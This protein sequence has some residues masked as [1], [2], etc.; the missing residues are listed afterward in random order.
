VIKKI[1][2][3][4]SKILQNDRGMALLLTIT[5]ITLFVAGAL[6]LNKRVRVAVMSTATSRDR[7]TLLHMASSGVHAAMAMLVKDRIDSDTDSL[8]EDWADQ[9]ILNDLVMDI[10]FE[11]G[12]VKITIT[13]EL[14]KI[15]VNALVDFPEGTN[16]KEPQRKMWDRFLFLFFSQY[17]PDMRSDPDEIINSLKDWLDS[18]D[19]DVIT[20]LSGAESDYYQD[21][22]PPY[23]CRNGP[24]SYLGELVL[25][26]GITPEIFNDLGQASGLSRYMTV[27]GMTDAGGNSFTYKGKININTADPPVIAGMLPAGN[28]DLALAISEYRRET[29]DSV[30]IHDLSSP[31][32]YKNAPGCSDIEIDPKIIT[33]ASNFFQI[34][35]I[36]N[37]H[38]I[39][40]ILRVVVHREKESKTGKWRCMVLSWQEGQG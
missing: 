37:L 13:D 8:H 18:K 19:D 30:Y 2:Q 7:V 36:A 28:E 40:M 32:W 33:T 5:V 4:S 22:D 24:I 12:D 20:G 34:E 27:Y 26:R 16:F 14:G 17:D 39:K 11:D 38:E 9:D 1:L 35:S 29:S 25:V 23:L 3:N 6:E 10:P 31:T 15:Q 21:L